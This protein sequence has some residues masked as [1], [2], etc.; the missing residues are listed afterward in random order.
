MIFTS[1]PKF[2]GSGRT[3]NNQFKN[4]VISKEKSVP[5]RIHWERADRVANNNY[6]KDN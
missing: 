1:D 5:Q 3:P 6:K 2:L 4:P